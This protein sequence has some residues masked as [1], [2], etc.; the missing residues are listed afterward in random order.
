MVASECGVLLS[1]DLG[2]AEL[3]RSQIKMLLDTSFTRADG[4]LLVPV[5]V[6]PD[7]WAGDM[8][9]P[10]LLGPRPLRGGPRTRSRLGMGP[11]GHSSGDRQARKAPSG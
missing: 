5:R 4:H 7:G 8:E 6:A 10:V 1:G 11:F 3:M 2:Y 9:D